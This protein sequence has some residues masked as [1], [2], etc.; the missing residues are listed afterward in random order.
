MIEYETKKCVRLNE[1]FTFLTY[2]KENDVDSSDV[3][4]LKF[5]EEY[6]DLV[7]EYFVKEDPFRGNSHT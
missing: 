1:I 6:F 5:D 2:E 3:Y 7:N 4:G